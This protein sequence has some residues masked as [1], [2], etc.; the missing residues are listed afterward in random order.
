MCWTIVA[1]ANQ[2]VIFRKPVTNQCYQDRSP[3]A[4]PPLCAPQA[5]PDLG[6]KTPMEACITPLPEGERIRAKR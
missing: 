1:H 5:P 4:H 3:S 2:T 6:W